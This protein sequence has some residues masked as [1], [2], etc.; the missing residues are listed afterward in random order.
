ML[1]DPNHKAK[2]KATRMSTMVVPVASR[3][4][5]RPSD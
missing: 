1:D 2:T 3:V 4:N 5:N